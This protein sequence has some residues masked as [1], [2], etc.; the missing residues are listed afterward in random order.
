LIFFNGMHDAANSIATVVS[1]RVLSPRMAVIWA[2]F[3]NFAAFILFNLIFNTRVAETMGTGV[4]KHDIAIN[5]PVIAAALVGAISW[6]IF[7][8]RVGLPVSS[9]HALVGGLLG[10]AVTHSDLA[11]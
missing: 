11:W 8:W 6:N 3:F 1:T 7:T 2:A 10:A 4:V 9:S 5:I